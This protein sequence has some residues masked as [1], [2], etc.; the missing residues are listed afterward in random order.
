MEDNEKM[1][2]NFVHLARLALSQ[3]PQD[4][5]SFLHRVC[6][7]KGVSAGVVD[8]INELLHNAPSR[9]TPLR[10]TSIT[11]AVPSDTDSR[12]QLLRIEEAPEI[13][14]DPHY[15]IQIANSLSN[16]V[17]ERQGLGTLAEMGLEPT[18][19][20]LFTGPPGVGKTLAARWIANELELPLLVLDLSSVMSSFLGRTGTNLRHVIEY[21]KSRECV[22]LLDELDAIAKRRDDLGEIGELK[23]LVTVLLQLLD[24]WPASGLL[25]SAT[26]HPDLLDPAVWRRFD[27]TLKFSLPDQSTAKRFIDDLLSPVDPTLSKWSEPLSFAMGGLSF[28]E[29]EREIS[30]AKRH[31]ALGI[32][33]MS[34]VLSSLVVAD[35]IPKKHRI[36]LAASLVI[37]GLVSQRQAHEMTGIAR[38]TIRR[39]VRSK[40][41]N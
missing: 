14:T 26:N 13:S 17:T 19:K 39:R 25:L 8:S 35:D 22:L 34:S 18:K 11:D 16:I 31:S 20:V 32:E 24:D 23:R 7:Q 1:S 30:R 9:S 4:V 38:D 6:R 3:R 5:H 29:I 40:G 36:D 2:R 12:Y 41:V 27:Q 33:N 28:S 37:A 21:A 15:S 10:K